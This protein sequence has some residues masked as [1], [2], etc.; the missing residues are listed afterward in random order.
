MIVIT[1]SYGQLGNR[2]FLYAHLIA[3]ARHYGVTLANPCFAEYAHLFPATENDLWCRY[4]A[5]AATS[6]PTPWR[7]RLLA[8]SVYL[9]SRVFSTLGLTK[10]PFSIVRLRGVNTECD[11]AGPEFADLMKRSRPLLADGWLFRS[12]SLLRQH[13]SAIREHFRIQPENNQRVQQL[14]AEIRG[15]A[16][17]VVGVHIRHGDYATYEGGRY[18]YQVSEYVAA[19]RRVAE[20]LAPRRVAFLVCSNAK[21]QSGAFGDL[22]IVHGTGDVI[23]DLYSFANT[24]LLIGPPSTFTLWASFYGN[25][26]LSMLH[27]ADQP[28]DTSAVQRRSAA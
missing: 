24:D 5:K 16:D 7:R 11:L 10:Y 28:I 4:P 14:I 26:P 27:T 8:K 13:A 1:K 18:F 23:E 3:A 2:L 9:G 12:E 19:M 21:F 15:Q 20:Q 25:V 17:V 22:N 6:K